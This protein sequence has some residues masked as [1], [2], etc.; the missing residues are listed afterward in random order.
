MAPKFCC[1]TLTSSKILI[2][3]NSYE[4]KTVRGIVFGLKCVNGMS[5][6][7]MFQ[8]FGTKS[9]WS[10]GNLWPMLLG[11]ANIICEVS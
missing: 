3:A 1:D 10:Y 8:S 5:C 2:N 4:H 11:W 9:R 7:T 6:F